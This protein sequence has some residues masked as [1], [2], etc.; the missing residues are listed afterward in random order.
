LLFGNAIVRHDAVMFDPTTQLDQ[1]PN[2]LRA[3]EVDRVRA[4]EQVLVIHPTPDSVA[5]LIARGAEVLIAGL[6]GEEIRVEP[7]GGVSVFAD[8]F[9]S[10]IAPDQGAVETVF[11]QDGRTFRV[12]VV[13]VG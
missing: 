8:T 7:R 11:L 12:D 10:W 13:V 1:R 6:Q 2:M 9:V 4:G 3:S 5:R